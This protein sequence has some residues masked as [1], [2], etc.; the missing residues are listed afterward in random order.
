[1]EKKQKITK[2]ALI[3]LWTAA[4]K[5]QK[6]K[7]NFEIS[8]SD[9]SPF[10]ILKADEES[11]IIYTVSAISQGPIDSP[12]YNYSANIVFG[13]F[14]EYARFELDRSEFDSLV[15][16]FVKQKEITIKNEINKIVENTE[17]K[18]LE[19]LKECQI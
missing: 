17:N 11:N 8:G 9:D 6:S 18:L 14:V 4:C 7:N 3:A 13:E 2:E 19:M 5:K 15:D 1:M 10:Y 16:L 12:K